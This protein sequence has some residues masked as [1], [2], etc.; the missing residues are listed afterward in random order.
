MVGVGQ[1]LLPGLGRRQLLAVAADHFG[2]HAERVLGSA[3]RGHRPEC[4][5]AWAVRRS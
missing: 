5:A 2:E 3:L 1:G 4:P